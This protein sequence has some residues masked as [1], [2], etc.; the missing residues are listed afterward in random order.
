[1]EWP[2]LVSGVHLGLSLFLQG[3]RLH[4][5][6]GTRACLLHLYKWWKSP[7]GTILIWQSCKQ[8]L[9]NYQPVLIFFELCPPWFD[10]FLGIKYIEYSHPN[11]PRATKKSDWEIF[12]PSARFRTCR[13]CQASQGTWHLSE[14]VLDHQSMSRE[15]QNYFSNLGVDSRFSFIFALFEMEP[16]NFV[17][18]LFGC[19]WHPPDHLDG[20]VA[21]QSTHCH[22]LQV[23]GIPVQAGTAKEIIF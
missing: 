18:M 9:L 11:Q 3:F 20:D 15:Y 12:K 5:S 7:P 19:I 10:L 6:L 23:L 22:C 4:F 8:A 16:D 17:S 13:T 1:M 21:G 14:P 2:S